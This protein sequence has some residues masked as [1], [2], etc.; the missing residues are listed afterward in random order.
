MSETYTIGGDTWAA[1]LGFDI[2]AQT[3]TPVEGHIVSYFDADL[4]LFG[5]PPPTLDLSACDVFH[6]PVGPVLAVGY[7]VE[8]VLTMPPMKHRIRYKLDKPVI[9]L[10]DHVYSMWLSK[11]LLH[12]GG[13]NQWLYDKDDATYPRGH[14]IHSDDGGHTWT[15][16]PNSCFMFCEFGDPPL[17]SPEPYPPIYY[18][19]CLDLKVFH[20]PTSITFTL[21]SS[22]PC[23][24]TCFYTEVKPRKHPTERVIRGATVPWATYFCFVAWKMVEQ[25]E[26]GDSLYHTFEMPNWKYC[27]VRW[28]TFRGTVHDITSPSIG[29]VFMHHHTGVEPFCN[30]GFEDYYFEKE[31]PPCWVPTAI[32]AGNSQWWRNETFV[33]EGNYSMM[34]GASASPQKTRADQIRYAHPYRGYN[35]KFTFWFYKPRRTTT[36]ISVRQT[37]PH[38]WLWSSS[39]SLPTGWVKTEHTHLIALDAETLELRI[40][41]DGFP[42]AA[43]VIYWDDFSVDIVF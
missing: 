42:G 15:H 18:F 32:G 36:T 39:Q 7:P 11:A 37:G 26:P 22:V 24:L 27:Q 23:H 25:S 30:L 29:P 16:F 41:T 6:N 14:I 4:W 31:C 35:V 3:F 17:L 21:S 20:H 43:R 19:A 12:G 38:P 1:I 10:K 9:L 33:R 13:D 8:P 34:M 40:Q 28:F 2:L 5:V